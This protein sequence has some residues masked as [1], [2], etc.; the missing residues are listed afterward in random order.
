MRK[1]ISAQIDKVGEAQYYDRIVGQNVF[2]LPEKDYI[3]RCCVDFG[4]YIGLFSICAAVNTGCKVYSF[5][6]DHEN[7]KKLCTNIQ[8]NKLGGMIIPFNKGLWS[9]DGVCQFYED[10]VPWQGQSNSF[11]PNGGALM[12]AAC[13]TAKTAFEQVKEKIFYLKCNCEGGEI[14]L[15]K[16]LIENKSII[17]DPLMFSIE[18]HPGLVD[19]KYHEEM[20]AALETIK[21]KRKGM[22][23]EIRMAYLKYTG[24]KTRF[25]SVKVNTL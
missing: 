23:T 7:F 16:Y 24:D 1:W 22:K 10:P 17:D 8:L 21:E 11:S 3:G 2:K 18:I 20:L 12:S 13:L 25:E 14:Y 15:L 19:I 6:P 5:E 9:H 4:A